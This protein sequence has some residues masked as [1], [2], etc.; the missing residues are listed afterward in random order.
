MVISI[1]LSWLIL[2]GKGRPCS[3][4]PTNVSKLIS[5]SDKWMA[6]LMRGG[7]VVTGECGVV[8]FELE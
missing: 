3:E 6:I 5:N 2:N 4:Q 1:H 8:L 7:L